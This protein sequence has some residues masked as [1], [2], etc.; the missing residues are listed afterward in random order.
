[1]RLEYAPLR[2]GSIMKSEVIVIY[3]SL[4]IGNLLIKMS[5]QVHGSRNILSHLI[6]SALIILK[7][8]R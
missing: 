2:S 6:S 1:M 7:N 5:D 4:C 3:A 8:I